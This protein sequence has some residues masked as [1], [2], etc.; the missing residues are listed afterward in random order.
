MHCEAD[1]LSILVIPS[2]GKTETRLPASMSDRQASA[3]R[4]DA[5]GGRTVSGTVTGR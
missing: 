3:F 2:S 5:E 4:R 1:C